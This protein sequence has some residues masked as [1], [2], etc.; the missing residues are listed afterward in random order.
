M[1]I[2]AKLFQFPLSG[3]CPL[4]RTI[5]PFGSHLRFEIGANVLPGGER[6]HLAILISTL[7][8]TVIFG[9]IK[10]SPK[11]DA[12]LTRLRVLMTH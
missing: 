8:H 10:N 9:P 5:V 12:N 6:H 3:F 7:R 4:G 2:D 11:L 1:G